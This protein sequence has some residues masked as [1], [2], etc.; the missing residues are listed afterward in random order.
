M[1]Y[2][3]DIL[4][5]LRDKQSLRG[6]TRDTGISRKAVTNYRDIARANGWLDSSSSLPTKEELADYLTKRELK[7]RPPQNVSTVE[8]YRE[9]VERMLNRNYTFKRIHELLRENFG[10][11]GS[12]SSVYR[13]CTKLNPPASQV[14][15]R[16]ITDPGEYAQIDFGTVTRHFEGTRRKPLYVFIMTLC[17]SRHMYVEFVEDQKVETFIRCHVDA[18][19]FFGGV[20]GIVIPDNLKAAVLKASFTDPVLSESYRNCARHYG[21]RISPTNPR[22]PEHKG[23]VESGI[24]YVKRAYCDGRRRIPLAELNRSV[25][26][27]CIDEAGAR[28]HG[29]TKKHPIMLFEEE[30]REAMKPLPAHPYELLIAKRLKLSRDCHLE[31]DKNYYSAP[32]KYVGEELE[33]YADQKLVRIYKGMELLTTHERCYDR[34]MTVTRHEHYPESKR[35]WFEYNSEK[36]VKE[37]EKIGENCL[38][39]VK[40]LLSDAVQDKLPS[41]RNLVL[42]RRDYD[43]GRIEAAC[44]RAL[45]YGDIRYVRIKQVLKRGMES[46]TPDESDRLPVSRS[47]YEYLRSASDFFGEVVE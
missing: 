16:V 42:L 12:K 22:T 29:T 30:E 24:K 11:Q 46:I 27:W 31:F 21:F 34:G 3:Y 28:V 35:I 38:K 1:N 8:P 7:Y 17:Y 39:V 47:D 14:T 13:F 10:Y 4:H 25:R 19:N 5:R 43:D 45:H 23:K 26:R 32:H 2:I 37:A 20:P 6:I 36:C 15:C 41:V 40:T 9:E 44:L 18:F 33:I